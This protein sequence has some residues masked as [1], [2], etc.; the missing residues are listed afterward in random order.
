[1]DAEEPLVYEYEEITDTG[2]ALR[3]RRVGYSTP[4][5]DLDDATGAIIGCALEVHRTLEPGF[6]EIVYQRAL[7]L[8]LQMADLEFDREVK[9][10]IFYEG[11]QIDTRRRMR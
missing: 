10:P 5:Y 7:A 3:A 8:E 1:M 11:H 6:R 4:G 9:V 2:V